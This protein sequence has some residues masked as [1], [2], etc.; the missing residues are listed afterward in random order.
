MDRTAGLN[1]QVCLSER[2]I[3]LGRNAMQCGGDHLAAGAD[4]FTT[5]ALLPQV[6]LALPSGLAIPTPSAT[7]RGHRNREVPAWKWW[8]EGNSLRE[9]WSQAPRVAPVW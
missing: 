2:R 1:E 7:M 9:P 6:G 4:H 8:T 5:F 3:A